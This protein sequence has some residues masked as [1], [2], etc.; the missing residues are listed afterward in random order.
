MAMRFS[1]RETPVRIKNAKDVDANVIGH[2]LNRIAEENGGRLTPRAGVDAARKRTNPIH[3]HLEWDDRVAAEGYRRD[4]I[5]EL[6]RIIV[7]DDPDDDDVPAR[8]YFHSIHD[9]DGTAYRTV[10]EIL[11]SRDL[12]LALLQQAEKD[13]QSWE[14][15][16]AELADICDLVRSARTK[17]RKK[18]EASKGEARPR[19]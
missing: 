14:R 17:L 1:F 6:I 13:L 5:S 8:R 7:R 3:R 19:A 11:K 18:I 16:Y 4:Q 15:R 12:Q 2:A 9:A 10:D